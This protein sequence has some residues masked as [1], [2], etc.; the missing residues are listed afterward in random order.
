MKLLLNTTYDFTSA[1][2]QYLQRV[3]PGL[4]IEQTFDAPDKL[5]GTDVSIL[6]TEQVPR[7][8]AAWPDLR[9]VQLLSAGA[10]QLIGHPILQTDIPVTTA[11]GTH[12]VPIAQFITCTWLMMMHRM[13]ELLAFKPTRNRPNRGALAGTTLRGL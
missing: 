5:D 8:L 7:N 12:G 2:R 6:V 3:W 9:W 11:S 1:H 4:D 13:P 10:N